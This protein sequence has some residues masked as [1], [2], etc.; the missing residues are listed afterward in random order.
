MSGWIAA[1]S[2][3]MRLLNACHAQGL[4]CGR[5]RVQLCG[6]QPERLS[7]L[8]QLLVSTHVGCYR[9][10]AYALKGGD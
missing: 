7:S 4:V 2:R 8:Q 9:R 1:Y 6:H 3:L 5:Q 10:L